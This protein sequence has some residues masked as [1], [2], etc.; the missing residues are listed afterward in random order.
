MHQN[1]MTPQFGEK[2][3]KSKNN[4]YWRGEIKLKNVKNLKH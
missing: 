3:N 4:K 1:V 2:V